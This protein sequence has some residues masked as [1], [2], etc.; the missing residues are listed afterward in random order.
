MGILLLLAI[1][2]PLFGGFFLAFAGKKLGPR[3]GWLA[4]FFPVF[5]FS[6]IVVHLCVVG[7]QNGLV[8]FWPWI[9]SLDINFSILADG[10]STFYGL[11]VSGM[12][13]LIVLYSC[14]YMDDHAKDHGRFYAYLVFFMAS[15]LGTVFSDNL[16]LLFVFW[17][18]T[19]IASFLLIGF[20]YEKEESRRGARMA[21]LVTGS[22]GLIMMAGIIFLGVQTGTYSIT[23]ITRQ[24]IDAQWILQWGNLAMILILIGAFG[25][26]A[27]FPFYFWLP[28]AMAAP[29]PVS[30]YL[31][32]ATMVMLGVFLTARIYPIFSVCS[33]WMP[34]L[35]SVGMVTMLIGAIWALFFSDLKQ[36][37]AY[38]TVSQLGVFIAFYG[39]AA[40]ELVVH[41]YLHI[42]CHTFYKGSLFM[43][44]GIIDHSLGTRDLHRIG[45]CAR[46]LPMVSLLVLIGCATMAG[47]PG[48]IGF[49]SKELYINEIFAFKENT[50]FFVAILG[51]FAVAATLKFIIGAR[52]IWTLYWGKPSPAAGIEHHFHKPSVLFILPPAILAFAAVVLGVFPALSEPLWDGLV[53]TGIH[54]LELPHLHIWHGWNEMLLTSLLVFAVGIGFFALLWKSHWINRLELPHWM[55]MDKGFDWSIDHL[56]YGAYSVTR[57]LRSNKPFDYLLIVVSAFVLTV[58][59]AMAAATIRNPSMWSLLS[60]HDGGEISPLR[61]FIAI[62]ICIGVLGVLFRR[63]WTTQ[64]LCLSVSGFLVSIYFVLYRAPDL[65]MT[66]LLVEAMTLVMILLL[67]GRFPKEAQMGEVHTALTSGRKMINI[68]VSVLAGGI[69]TCAMLLSMAVPR[70]RNVSEFYLSSSVPLAQGSNVVNVILVDFRGFDT[71][72]E[73]TVLVI[74]MLGCLGLLMRRKRTKEEYLKGPTGQAGI[75]NVHMEDV[76]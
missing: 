51:G 3:C 18:M 31:H 65:A 73:I 69:V 17:E 34:L 74:A 56:P 43:L 52:I 42:A 58:A 39:L 32:S 67:L 30:A 29:T 27:Q 61:S 54:T 63:K 24:G 41:D 75:V 48:T 21:L 26:S 47:I 46:K 40:N 20:N 60:V 6:M 59:G 1:L 16:M 15:M 38:M 66:Q 11:V 71:L 72:G 23:E 35:V 33:A 45:G 25:K 10:L 2:V 14:S 55:R 62:L 70:D 76:K 36:V 4:L 13:I 19:G 28:N 12:G 64:L 49:I 68:I 53:V 50:W 22:T 57:F 5:S 9:P 37:L 44:A 8:Y 7:A